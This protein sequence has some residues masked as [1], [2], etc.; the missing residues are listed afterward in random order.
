MRPLLVVAVSSVA[1]LV[2]AQAEKSPSKS[3][4]E[5]ER[6]LLT[7]V[8][9]VVA[10]VEEHAKLEFQKPPKVRAATYREWRE[11]VQRELEIGVRRE[12]F[13]ASVRTLGSAQ[14]VTIA[15]P[16]LAA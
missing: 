15:R 4:G 10:M 12:V 5:Q 7:A 9:E 2:P 11:I 3:P 14:R 13:E 6:R 8:G 1:A 16:A